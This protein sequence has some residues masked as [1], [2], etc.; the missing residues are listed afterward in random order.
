M[1]N[2]RNLYEIVEEHLDLEPIGV[3]PLYRDEG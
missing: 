3:Q 2:G 1:T